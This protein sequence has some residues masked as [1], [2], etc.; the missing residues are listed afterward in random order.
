MSTKNLRKPKHIFIFAGSHCQASEFARYKQ[1]HPSNWTY[2]HR[3]NQLH[4]VSKNMLIIK[5]GTW[6][7]NKKV[8]DIEEVATA[9][10]AVWCTDVATSKGT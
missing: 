2:L 1:L 3:P 4:G 5:V 6:Y 8:Y 7:M 10:E 9:R